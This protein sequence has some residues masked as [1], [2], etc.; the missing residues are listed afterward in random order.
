MKQ[1]CG[2][3]LEKESDKSAKKGNANAH[4]NKTGMKLKKYTLTVSRWFPTTAQ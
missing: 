3:K 1:L 4:R 2:H